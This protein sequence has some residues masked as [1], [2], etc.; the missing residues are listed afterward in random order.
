MPTY[1]GI[2]KVDQN[3]LRAQYALTEALWSKLIEQGLR[4]RSEGKVEAVFFADH[5]I[6][7]ASLTAA[8]DVDRQWLREITPLDDGSGRLRVKVVTPEAVLTR[9]AFLE[10]VEVMMVAAYQHGC[11]FDGFQVDVSAIRRRPWWSIW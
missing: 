9:K 5:E 6:A 4:E 2:D 8:F 11:V 3:A 1:A 10:L 7:A